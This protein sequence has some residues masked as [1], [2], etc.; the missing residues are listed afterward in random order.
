MSQANRAQKIRRI[1]DL[2]VVMIALPVLLPVI[3]AMALAIRLTSPGP[4]VMRLTRQGH[5]GLEFRQFRFR[6]VWMD[7]GLRAL[8]GGEGERDPRVTPLGDFLLRHRLNTLPLIFNVLAGSMALVGPAARPPLRG[9]AAPC[10]VLQNLR[11]GIFQPEQVLAGE[12]LNETDRQALYLAWARQ[13]HPFGDLR[14]ILRG[15]MGF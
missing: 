8:R 2:T 12:D 6:C 3:A 10:A 15:V 1:V 5:G 13:R 9:G 4:G 11:P 7:A 14:I